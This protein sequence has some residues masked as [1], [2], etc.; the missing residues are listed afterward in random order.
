MPRFPNFKPIL[1]CFLP[2]YNYDNLIGPH[3]GNP[4]V[5]GQEVNNKF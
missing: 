4:R 5:T 3:Y 2:Y 1:S